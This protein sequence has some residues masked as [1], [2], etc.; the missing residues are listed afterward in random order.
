MIERFNDSLHESLLIIQED[1][2]TIKEIDSNGNIS[3]KIDLPELIRLDSV[4]KGIEEFYKK[5]NDG[6]ELEWYSDKK[7]GIG[8][9]IKLAETK[10]LFSEENYI[11]YDEEDEEDLKY[12]HPLDLSN[13]GD[14][15][16]FYHKTRC[17]IQVALLHECK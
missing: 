10:Y 11:F 15:C 9:K 16:R 14:L 12:F 7:K 1:F 6:W 8:G 17:Y 4:H 2:K 13:S 5:S 3:L